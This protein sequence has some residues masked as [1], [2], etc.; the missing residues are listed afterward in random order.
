MLLLTLPPGHGSKPRGWCGRCG[1]ALP[2][3]VTPLCRMWPRGTLPTISTG[4]AAPLMLT[5]RDEGL[6]WEAL[7]GAVT[8]QAARREDSHQ[9]K[10]EHLQVVRAIAQQGP[11]LPSTQDL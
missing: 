2:Q 7:K 5:T 10:G 11:C 4:S 8:H 9:E 3:P 1:E 6:K